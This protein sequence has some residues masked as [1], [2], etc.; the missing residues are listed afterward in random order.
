MLSDVGE[1]KLRGVLWW[2]TSHV[3]DE[4]LEECPLCGAL[5]TDLRKHREWHESKG[6][7]WPGMLD[8]VFEAVATVAFA[9]TKHGAAK[10]RDRWRERRSSRGE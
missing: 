3:S 6:D 5:F 9:W 4:D 2:L 10:A 7:T 8:V 1:R